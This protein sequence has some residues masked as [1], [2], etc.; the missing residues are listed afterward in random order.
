VL[1]PLGNLAAVTADQGRWLGRVGL[2][3]GGVLIAYGIAERAI[4]PLIVG[5]LG[6]LG[7]LHRLRPGRAPAQT[8]SVLLRVY[9]NLILL[10]FLAF[11]VGWVVWGLVKGGALILA[12]IAMGAVPLYAVF[13]RVTQR[14]ELL[15]QALNF[16]GVGRRGGR[17]SR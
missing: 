15:P 17:P 7:A 4:G 6:I 11:G 13:C 2:V 14:C 10:I 16:T 5:G 8:P 3:V 12:G 9:Q 1:D